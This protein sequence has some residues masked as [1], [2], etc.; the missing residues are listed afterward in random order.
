MK[1]MKEDSIGDH[2][3]YVGSTLKKVALPNQIDDWMVSPLK[4][5]LEL[6]K[7]SRGIWKRVWTRVYQVSEWS[8]FYRLS[9]RT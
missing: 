7:V 5:V 6:W 8:I 3:I 1:Q 2:E 4:Y 9:V